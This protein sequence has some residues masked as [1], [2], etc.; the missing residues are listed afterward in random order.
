MF[1]C[2]IACQPLKRSSSY[3]SD[4][5]QGFVSWSVESGDIFRFKLTKIPDKS[6]TILNN[7]SVVLSLSNNVIWNWNFLQYFISAHPCWDNRP[8]FSKSMAQVEHWQIIKLTCK[9]RI[10][11]IWYKITFAKWPTIDIISLAFW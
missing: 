9:I 2:N 10:S 3:A 8:M 5:I 7:Y 1:V 4:L 6:M 11:F